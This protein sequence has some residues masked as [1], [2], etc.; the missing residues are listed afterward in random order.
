MSA[1]QR[2]SPKSARY[3]QTITSQQHKVI[4]VSELY[5]VYPYTIIAKVSVA[6]ARVH[7][8]T[9]S[10]LQ[11][12]KGFIIE[13]NS[14][15]YLLIL[16]TDYDSYNEECVLIRL[17]P[18]RKYSPTLEEVREQFKDLLKYWRTHGAIQRI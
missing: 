13:V 6:F 5:K 16:N 3:Y 17:Y 11:E 18:K 10:L 7:N 4:K 12:K 15:Y 1:T 9:L 2:L 8:T 14:E